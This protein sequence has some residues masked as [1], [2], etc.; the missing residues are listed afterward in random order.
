VLWQPG[1][2]LSYYIGAAGGLAQNGDGGRAS[3]RQ[4]NG[5]VETRRGGFLI[6]GGRDPKAT[7]GATILVPSKPPEEY[8]DRTG[9]YA[10]LA[11]MIAST[12]TIMIALTR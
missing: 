2:R 9:L 3:V 4:A 10:A 6:F 11:S 12:A 7:A 5:E 8:R 1:R